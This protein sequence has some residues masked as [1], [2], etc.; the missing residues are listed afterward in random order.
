MVTLQKVGNGKYD[1][2]FVDVYKEIISA[3]GDGGNVTLLRRGKT[4]ATF[5]HSYPGKIVELYTFWV[6]T[7]GQPKYDLVQSK[8]GDSMQ[9][10]K[11]AIMVGTCGTINFKLID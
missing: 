4:D 9:I 10:H 5:V 1:I 6:D 2:L 7:E 11:S 8:G 3:I